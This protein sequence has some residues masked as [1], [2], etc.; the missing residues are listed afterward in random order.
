MDFPEENF[1]TLV[2]C[3][4]I[5]FLK[6]LLVSPIYWWPHFFTIYD[7]NQVSEFTGNFVFNWHVFAFKHL[8][9]VKASNMI[10]FLDSRTVGAFT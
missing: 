10:N 5:L 6:G 8:I 4:Y 9:R 2:W 1:W 3:S 7:V